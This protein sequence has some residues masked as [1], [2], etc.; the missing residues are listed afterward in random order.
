MGELS[1]PER[2]MLRALQTREGNW[3]LEEILADCNWTDQAIATGAGHGLSNKGLVNIKES[4]S[5]EIKLGQQ[6]EKAAQEGLL[7][8]RIWEWIQSQTSPG[9]K[10]LSNVFERH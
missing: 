2:R 8:K 6:G 3:T 10:D 4:S 5:I 1:N 7:E 9:M